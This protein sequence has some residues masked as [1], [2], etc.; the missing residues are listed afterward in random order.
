MRMRQSLGLALALARAGFRE[1]NEGSYLG[2]LWYLIGPLSMFIVLLLV[3]S[4]RVGQGIPNYPA[5]L[6]LGLVIFSFFRKATLESSKAIVSSRGLIKSMNFP[7]ES[8]VFSVVLK[9]LF[10]HAFEMVLFAALLVYMNAPLIGLLAYPVLLAFFC[11]FVCGA[12]LLLSALSVHLADMDNIWSFLSYLLWLGTPI[13]Y[14][15]G[16]QAKLLAVSL[17][18]PMYYF[19][20][21]ARDIMIYAR[22]PEWW[23]LAGMVAYSI[24]FFAAGMLVFG[25]LKG[26]FAEMV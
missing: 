17:I 16:G 26:K 20:T 8:L 14:S 15:I 24:A 11:L 7:R 5:Y 23:L 4:D 21:I 22:M 3:F 10:S 19:I 2:V 18:N 25:R 9:T 12:C 13:F 1:K 6:L